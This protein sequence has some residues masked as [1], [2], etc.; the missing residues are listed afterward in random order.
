MEQKFAEKTDV[1]TEA[2]GYINED[3][4]VIDLTPEA[5]DVLGYP[6]DEIL[7]MRILDIVVDADVQNGREIERHLAG[8]QNYS[9]TLIVDADGKHRLI[10]SETEPVSIDG[11]TYLKHYNELLE[12][13]NPEAA[14]DPSSI[15]FDDIDSDRLQE[16]TSNIRVDHADG[17]M[18]LGAIMTDLAYGHN[19]IQQYKEGALSLHQAIDE[20]LAEEE[21]RNP[22]SQEVQVL[23]EVKDS[24]FGLYLRIQRGDAELHGDRDGEYSGYFE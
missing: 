16:I 24:A 1:S 2:V 4:E 12:I 19:E 10:G 3:S 7:G 8:E 23:K 21:Q 11:Q 20:R 15:D 18:N 6:R 17:E 22:D 5:A 9:E 14:N 13:E